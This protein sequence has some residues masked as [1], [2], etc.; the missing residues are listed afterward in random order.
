MQ[1]N[2]GG[3]HSSDIISYHILHVQI[4]HNVHSFKGN[5]PRYSLILHKMT[6]TPREKTYHPIPPGGGSMYSCTHLERKTDDSV[7]QIHK[8]LLQ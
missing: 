6:A 7:I 4:I 3:C 5:I 2:K 1:I 8:P